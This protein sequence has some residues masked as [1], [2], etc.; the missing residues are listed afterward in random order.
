M[1]KIICE[2]VQMSQENLLFDKLLV[3]MTVMVFSNITFTK[4]EP[5]DL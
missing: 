5:Y 1:Q 4:N 3:V 2:L